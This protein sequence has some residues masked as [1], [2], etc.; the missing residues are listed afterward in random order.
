MKRYSPFVLFALLLTAGGCRQA[1]AQ[2]YVNIHGGMTLPQGYYADSRM[3]DHEWMLAQGHQM[4]VG[5]GRGWAAGIELSY[6]M[7]FH[8]N[9][10][11]VVSSEFMQSGVNRDVKD[12]YEQVYALRYSQCSQYEMT[13][14]RFRN[15]PVLAGVR[16][17]YPLT[18]LFDFYGE[19]MA[20][21]NI[22][23]IS[24]WTLAFTDGN[25]TAVDGQEFADYN[26]VK[27]CRYNTA[28]TFAF[29]LGAGVLINKMVSVGA[30]FNMLGRAPL[31]WEQ[32]ELTRYSIYTE[33]RENHNT[34][35]IDYFSF[36]PTLVAVTVGFRLKAFSGAR[37]VQDW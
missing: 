29:R 37:H 20:G 2:L 16:Y 11:A 7:P 36:N 14:P 17:C 25:W 1:S 13:L 10:E 19:A 4:K 15:V 5:A 33:V 26:N 31:S 8:T 6:A 3:S 23:M 24:D 21:L 30:S 12:Y 22:R 28:T 32:D 9:L 35:Q 18:K 27:I 34:N